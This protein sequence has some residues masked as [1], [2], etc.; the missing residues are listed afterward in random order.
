MERWMTT[1][2]PSI[3]G[4]TL[5]RT[6][7]RRLRTRQK[8]TQLKDGLETAVAIRCVVR[9]TQTLISALRGHSTTSAKTDGLSCAG[10]SSTFST[11][12]NS[13]YLSA[14]FRVAPRGVFRL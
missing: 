8:V 13:D 6:P 10:K 12:L 11:I 4:S 14:I 7:N 2:E 5:T 9:V 3:A 1:S